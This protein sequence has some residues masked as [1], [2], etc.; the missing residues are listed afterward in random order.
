MHPSN[1]K[2]VRG[3]PDLPLI[4]PTQITHKG[5]VDVFRCGAR[6]LATSRVYRHSVTAVNGRDWVRAKTR[7]MR[8]DLHNIF[9]LAETRGFR[10]ALQ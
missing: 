3:I 8:G 6:T 5:E 2:V 1:L 10:V 4:G 7:E 9:N